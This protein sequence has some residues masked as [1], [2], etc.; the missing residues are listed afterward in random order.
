MK[1]YNH[2]NEELIEIQKNE[3]ASPKNNPDCE[4]YC[5]RFP[6]VKHIKECC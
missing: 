2:T 6:N 1:K 4:C 3:K 5:H